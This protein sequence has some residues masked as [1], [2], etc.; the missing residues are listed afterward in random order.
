VYQDGLASPSQ[1][2]RRATN[3]EQGSVSACLRRD[4]S[5]AIIHFRQ[6]A[7]TVLRAVDGTECRDAAGT[8]L[9]GLVQCSAVLWCGAVGLVARREHPDAR[10]ISVRCLAAASAKPNGSR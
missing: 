2:G 7:G 9:G 10:I 4:Q 1:Q 8:A 5:T 6:A 3:R